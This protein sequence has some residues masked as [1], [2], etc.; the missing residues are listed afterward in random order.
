QEVSESSERWAYGAVLNASAAV[1]MADVAIQWNRDRRDPASGISSGNVRIH[2]TNS[3]RATWTNGQC[4]VAVSTASI[5]AP[6]FDLDLCRTQLEHEGFQIPVEDFETPLRTALEPPSIRRYLFFNSSL[7]HF[8][9]AP[10]VYVVLWCAFY[11]SLHLYLNERVMNF[12]VLCLCVSLIVS[13]I[14]IAIILVFHYSNKEINVNTDV[15]LVKVNER[16]IG[17]GLLLGIADWVERCT[18]RMQLCCVFWELGPCQQTLTET[19]AELDLVG[20]EIKKKLKKRMSHLTVVAEVPPP[21][22]DAEE[23]TEEPHEEH[24]LLGG[25]AERRAPPEKR[26]EVVLT[27]TFNLLPDLTLSHQ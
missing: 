22:S 23:P 27:E 6:S 12:W 5:L 17:H 9:M 26:Q 8:I 4:V 21:E 2:R 10:I 20:D 11:S 16:L 18:G 13:V 24:P 25:A 3:G 19:L 1:H 14:T 15:R 7:F